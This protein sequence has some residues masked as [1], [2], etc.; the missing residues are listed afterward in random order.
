MPGSGPD[1]HFFR[2]DIE[3][4]QIRQ[5]GCV[6][7]SISDFRGPK[8]VKRL[9][10]SLPFCDTRCAGISALP[11]MFVHSAAPAKGA[12]SGF[13]TRGLSDFRPPVPRPVLR[14]Y[15][16]KPTPLLAS[17]M[18]VDSG[19]TLSSTPRAGDH[20]P[21]SAFLPLRTHSTA[22]SH[23]GLIHGL[24]CTVY[25][26]SRITRAP[27]PRTRRAAINCTGRQ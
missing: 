12:F 8:R 26:L 18:P 20:C 6:S 21:L 13:A 1:T 2:L 3:L 17:R 16:I 4:P 5:L 22:I 27:R 9:P 10:Y 23:S 14:A 7:L 19:C 24:K 15:A 25:P 11:S